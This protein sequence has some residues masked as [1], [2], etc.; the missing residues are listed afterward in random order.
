MTDSRGPTSRVRSRAAAHGALTAVSVAAALLG[1]EAVVRIFDLGPEISPV[2]R[3][4]YRLSENTALRYELIPGSPDGENRINSDGMRDHEHPVAK[5]PGVFRIACLGD[6]ITYGFGVPTRSSYPARLEDR[7]NSKAGPGVRFEVLNFGVTGYNITQSIENLRARGL[8]YRPDLVIYQYCLNDPQQYS[9]ELENLEIS[10]TPA[11]AGY[12][13]RLLSRGGRLLSGSRVFALAAFAWQSATPGGRRARAARP[14][15]QW[16][17]IRGGSYADYFSRLHA[18]PI[19]WRRIETGFAELAALG[20]EFGFEG[21]VVLF[22]VLANLADYPLA[23]VHE[24]VIGAARAA[25]LPQ[26][27]LLPVYQKAAGRGQGIAVNALHPNAM[28]HAF[29]AGSIIDALEAHGTLPRTPPS[30]ALPKTRDEKGEIPR[31]NPQ[32]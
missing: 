32:R 27:D 11:E 1:A 23:D 22:P 19:G 18:D 14:D 21:L 13:R 3:E 30:E 26:L 29:A 2:F 8:K 4:N 6:S 15:S 25:S 17:A 16:L 24:R 20:N 28:G 31:P 12:R 5:P 7:L 10:L 9:S